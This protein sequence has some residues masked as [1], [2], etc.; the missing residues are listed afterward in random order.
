VRSGAFE[1][2]RRG[3]ITPAPVDLAR[4]DRFERWQEVRS[5][6]LDRI[7]AVAET[8]K[9]PVVIAGYAALAIWN[10]SFTGT[11]PAFV[12][13]LEPPGSYRRTKRGVVVHRADF[14]DDEIIPWGD[15][16]VTSPA[17]TIA[18]LARAGDFAAAV[19]ALDHALSERAEAGQRLGKDAVL[20]LVERR[21]WG[22][23]GA[24]VTAAV[25]FADS[26]SGS[27]GES[28][29]RV[30]IFRMGFEMPEL[31]VRHP[32][33]DGYYDADFKWPATPNRPPTI[34]EFDGV[35][36]YAR[37]QYRDGRDAGEV[38]VAEKRREDY[39]RGLGNGFVRWV[40]SELRQPTRLLRPK[41]LG[42]GIRIVRRPQI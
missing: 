14:D 28:L 9:G 18:D 15:H 23:G 2:L 8:R 5:R 42:A 11:W 12:E 25:E 27:G 20:E 19:V 30:E 7:A 4:I 36:K 13:L 10:Y 1:R 37:A 32:Q 6:Y 29:S 40:W 26:R 33:P 22:R 34:G 39:L 38:V 35:L 41:L 16:F 24:R 3:V 21:G 31:Q 17:R